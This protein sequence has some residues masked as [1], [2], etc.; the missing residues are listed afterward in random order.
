MLA[1]MKGK[2]Y[3]VNSIAGMDKWFSAGQWVALH[4]EY[5]VNVTQNY[6]AEAPSD[7]AFSTVL[8]GTL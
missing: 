7:L 1:T 5:L 6:S 2:M 3:A 8:K 4:T